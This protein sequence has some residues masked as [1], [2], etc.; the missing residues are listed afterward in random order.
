MGA[1]LGHLCVRLIAGHLPLVQIPGIGRALQRVH[2][3][4]PAALSAPGTGLRQPHEQARL[5][6]APAH[7]VEVVW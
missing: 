6:A 1:D 7:L 5:D 2:R 4:G 3:A